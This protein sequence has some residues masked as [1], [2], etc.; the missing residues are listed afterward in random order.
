[1]DTRIYVC[2]HKKFD[3]PK[4]DMYRPIHV[5][6]S[7]SQDLGYEGDDQ[8]DSISEKN[9]SF[10]EL[11][12]MYWIWKNVECDIVGIAHYRRYLERDGKL[13]DQEYVERVLNEEGYDVIVP[14][15]GMSEYA[16]NQQHFEKT[17]YKRDYEVTRQV[18]L[19]KYPEYERAFDLFSETN[20]ASL[21]NMV[22]TRKSL[23][24]EYCSWLF[25]ILF[26]VEK[27][28]DVSEY[29]P[30]QARLYGYLSERLF[31]IWLFM[32]R[33]K[34]KEETLRIILSE[35]N[36]GRLV[37]FY[38]SRDRFDLYIAE[39]YKD[40]SA[41]GYECIAIDIGSLPSKMS[42]LSGFLEKPVTAAISFDLIGLEQDIIP[43]QDIWEA[44]GIPFISI[45]T[46]RR[47]KENTRLASSTK[48][49]L[50]GVTE[51]SMTD[52][53][54]EYPDLSALGFIPLAGRTVSKCPAEIAK[55]SNDVICP[56]ADDHVITIDIFEKMRDAKIVY[57]RMQKSQKDM[58]DLVF[59]SMLAGAVV[60][61]D[62]SDYILENYKCYPKYKK[63]DAE[64]V[65]TSIDEG[66]DSEEIIQGLL[67]D[68]EGMQIIADNGRRR[69]MVTDTW[70]A[71]ATELHRDLLSLLQ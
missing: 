42:E 48:A 36:L 24:D 66:K 27:R 46:E 22:I 26:E 15:S 32:H 37:F 38:G 11:T 70:S 63:E 29:I 33:Y 45:I 47:I 19:E 28:T 7:I 55:R 71:R 50:L 58:C 34:V 18:L 56:G 5:G 65:M 64:I 69:A 44:L 6:R 30:F 21:G 54:E 35:G 17:H 1:M 61:V 41:M 49:M 4:D 31:R 68:P 20:L 67:K 39:L 9:K 53:G 52:I 23:Y 3:P 8:G 59:S 40:L 12:G 57:I 10:C 16:N 13:L 14:A 2:T 51:E 25:D 62:A 60:I 43:G